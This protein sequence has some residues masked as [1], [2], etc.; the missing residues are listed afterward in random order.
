MSE[1][2][3]AVDILSL[4]NGGGAIAG[5]GETFA[6]N[7]FTGAG[8]AQV[9]IAV[10]AGRDGF[11]PDLELVYNSGSGNGPF[12]LGWSLGVPGV[13]RKTAKGVPVYDDEA[14]IFLL[15]QAEDLV[16]IERSGDTTSYRPRTE[17]TF[18]RIAHVRTTDQNYWEVRDTSGI[19]ARYG[20]PRPDD[21]D[22]SWSDP[23]VV[24]DPDPLHRHHIFSW[25]LSE[26]R[27]PFGN[28]VIYDYAPDSGAQIYLQRIRYADYHDGDET[29][30]LVEVRFHYERRPD[31][32]S[33]RRAGF[34]IRTRKRCTR[35]DILTHA[36]EPR[37]VRSYHLVYLDQRSD[38]P[39]LGARLP[40]NG[41]S[42]LSQVRIAGHDETTDLPPVEF[43]YSA[44]E[45][46]RSD[47]SAVIGPDLPA[48]SL[49]EPNMAVVDLDG[50]GLPDVLAFQ[51]TIRYWKNRGGGR[52]D[53]PREM[54]AAP[55]GVALGDEGVQLLDA[56]GN[57]RADLVVTR[58]PVTGY[59]PLGGDGQWDRRSFQA[60]RSAP[61]F[62]LAG[63]D[64]QL[65]DLTGDG[66]TDAVRAG[67]QLECFFHDAELGWRRS[68]AVS[69]RALEAFPN[70]EFSDPRVRWADMSGD[71]LTD[72]A[73]VY[74]GHIAYWPSLGHGSWGRRVSM[75]HCPRFPAG[76]DPHRV[77]VGDIDGDGLADVIYVDHCRVTVWINQGGAR[78][79]DPVILEGTPQ[80]T[81]RGTV[82]LLDL[83]GAG[84]AGIL[85]SE[86]AGGPAGHMWFLDVIGDRKPYLLD[87]I[88]NHRGATT[89]IHYAPSTRYSIADRDDP[90]LHWRTPLPFPLQVVARTEVI[91]QLSGGRL[92]T[93]FFY[94]H[95][96][97]D[98]VER[99]FRGF[100]RVDQ[101]DTETFSA[102]PTAHN[103]TNPTLTFS[104]PTES[105]TWFHLGPVELEADDWFELD[106]SA[107]HWPGDPGHL[108]RP[109][110]TAAFLRSLPRRA[111]RDA[112]RSLRGSVLRSELYSFDGSLRE[113]RPYSVT[114]TSYGIR[115]ESRPSSGEHADPTAR[116]RV[117]FPHPIASR[118]TQWERGADPMT[119]FTFTDRYNELGQAQRSISVAC[120]RGWRDRADQMAGFLASV[121][122]EDF[123]APLSDDV[124][125]RDRVARSTSYEL[126]GHGTVDSVRRAADTP[127]LLPVLGQEITYYD[128][129][130][131]T[132][133]PFGQ[134]GGY[135]L[136]ARSE[137]L[138]FT[139][140]ILDAA[141]GDAGAAPYLSGD[142]PLPSEYPP[143]FADS[144][145][146]RAG[147]H[148]HSADGV[149]IAGYYVAEGQTRYD[150]HD[151]EV[152]H[153][154]GLL[155]ATRDPLGNETTV[156]HDQP[157]QLLPVA[158]TDAVGL[159]TEASYDY[160]HLQV[161]ATIDAN[162]N[163]R[164]LAYDALGML[165]RSAVRGT[166]AEPGDSLEHPTTRF[167]RDVHA[168]ARD[169]SPAVTRIFQR[170]H[171]A[172]DTAVPEA[173]RDLVVESVQYTDGFG[174]LLQSRT[175]ASDVVFG[176]AVFGDGVLPAGQGD[177]VGTAADVIGVEAAGGEPPFV[178]V[179]GWTTYDN[180]G[181]VVEAYEPFYQRGWV[182]LARADAN[183]AAFGEKMTIYYDPLGRVVRRVHP[184]GSQ[185]RTIYGVPGRIDTPDPARPDRHEPTPWERYTYDA[186]D[187]A[188]VA[189]IV[190]PAPKSL[191]M[192]PTEHHFTPLSVELDAFGR[193]IRAV[194]RGGTDPGQWRTNTFEHDLANLIAATDALGRTAFRHVYDL[195][196]VQLR[197]ESID[198]GTRWVIVDAAGREI[199]RRDSKGA[200]VL[201]SYDSL[202]RLRRWWARDLTGEPVALRERLV[203]GDDEDAG[204]AEPAATNH[205]GALYRHYDEAGCITVERYDFTNNP[206]ESTRQVIAD[207]A[208]L[209]AFDGL[210]STD[211][212]PTYRVDWQ[213]PPGQSEQ[214]HRASLLDGTEYRIS[215]H[216]DALGRLLSVTYPQDVDGERKQARFRYNTGGE[217]E[218]A[219]LDGA[220]FVQHIAY[221]A[222]G[223]RTLVAYGNG[224]MTRYAY[225]SKT[226]ALV[227][228][229]SERYARPGAHRYRPQG[230]VVEDVAYRHDLVGNVQMIRNRTPQCG[231]P[232]TA[233]G[234]DA[235]DRQ[236]TYDPLYRLR[237]AT[238][239][240][241]AQPVA[242]PPWKQGLTSQDPNQTRA[243][244]EHYS[245]DSVGNL[246]RLAHNGGPGGSFTR[247]LTPAA[248]GNRLAVMS[249]GGTEYGY[250]YDVSGNMVREGASRHFEWDY[251]DQV[252][253][254]RVASGAVDSLHAHYLY[255]GSG[256]RT[257]K[258]VRKQNGNKIE[259]TINIAGLFEHHRIVQGNTVS[260]NNTLHVMDAESRLATV[261]V[262]A[263]FAGDDTPAVKYHLGDP[264]DTAGVVLGQSGAWINREEHT[265]YGET[266]FGG[267][268]YKRYRFAG[269]ERDEESGLDYHGARY[270][271]SWLGRW[272]SPDPA[273]PE[274][275]SN[276]YNF[277][278]GDPIGLDDP[279][280]LK[281]K[282]RKRKRRKGYDKARA[283]MKRRRAGHAG[284][285]DSGPS[286]HG[287]PGAKAGDDAWKTGKSEKGF[288]KT[289]ARQKGN[290]PRKWKNYPGTEAGHNVHHP[291]RKS[292]NKYPLNPEWSADNSQKGTIDTHR[293][294]QTR[295]PAPLPGPKDGRAY[296]K[297]A[298]D[299]PKPPSGAAELAKKSAKMSRSAAG[300]LGDVIA[301][302]A[303]RFVPGV[304]IAFGLHSAYENFEQGNVLKGIFDLGGVIPGPVGDVFDGIGTLY[305][306]GEVLLAEDPAPAEPE[307]AG[308]GVLE[309]VE[310]ILKDLE[311]KLEDALRP[312]LPPIPTPTPATPHGVPGR[313]P[314][315]LPPIPPPPELA[316]P[317]PQPPP[318]PPQQPIHIS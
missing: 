82:S 279:S 96:Y 215:T 37:L 223:T 317:P 124:Y 242:A 170:I 34:E 10:P 92:V 206:V 7:P 287:G 195:G 84:V 246:T 28:R 305:E 169:G 152:A 300:K 9:P 244:T 204:L 89:R 77:L 168:F 176:D 33:N 106:Y 61:S 47:L 18:A 164:A 125:I 57:G 222:S 225:D 59:Y 49:G 58:G 194:E 316:P 110:D 76:Y 277:A 257:K 162:G 142:G 228:R 99:E 133:L 78:F 247:A 214:A 29:Q 309:V 187:L 119:Q 310:G 153:P 208:I 157:Y 27:D 139:D 219:E 8:T 203:Y 236:F 290:S 136:P 251:A 148:R 267:Y 41:V 302:R 93:E 298:P 199:E 172:G 271:A 191:V 240:E 149:H 88:D 186:N 181:R 147:Y 229:R 39:G 230:P 198:S 275:E 118:S 137:K 303:K 97:Y 193:I 141:Y 281:P 116:P 306:V 60:Q 180:K 51:G 100:G 56:N 6:A 174:R 30:F 73:V 67:A 102:H 43:G 288:Y 315:D 140:D 179:S 25:Y 101:R 14:D 285:S 81:P 262:G 297:N 63:S 263:P 159:R 188:A 134:V 185:E 74:D 40:L 79:A 234:L 282:K 173:D 239:R 1:P 202:S 4:P 50:N 311:R 91:D 121:A 307:Q 245:Y 241:H 17:G 163:R 220:T 167:E 201:Q 44:F 308:P 66:I 211:P 158:V 318:P 151:P 80:V 13:V 150:V 217:L 48:Q 160:R 260:E 284:V 113:S 301:K 16:A 5:V 273:G 221:N 70:I 165:E 12:G 85:F 117:F 235:L 289:Q 249:S 45:P 90:V 120:P 209:S 52:F 15:S 115:E 227:R 184:D 112:V 145:P 272:T 283:D 146:A 114:E 122:V 31:S 293:R 24:A 75:A 226:F 32:F 295:N 259:V 154:R 265:P 250:E 19:T 71:G 292:G 237:S 72:I 313:I 104:P 189:A 261:R 69:R 216:H 224:V 62:D 177:A 255:D 108:Q 256:A 253:A 22:E 258:L 123:A 171:H 11:G 233:L 127:G 243:Y 87:T 54:G 254:F 212:V 135:G 278:F 161:V 3:S 252:R 266:S 68:R 156:E 23:A 46:K 312:L 280:G 138:V 218:S 143:A 294:P 231:I 210:S 2:K 107:E 197:T 205:L 132:G 64:V 182:Y 35:I 53:L 155:V 291:H 105:R 270:Y 274:D 26:T 268:A 178:V 55:Q 238:G 264:A 196:G 232:N 83:R 304:G 95:G 130:A 42:L 21:A 131:Y 98:G 190:D 314:L 213:P 20:T 175:R 103:D 65:V 111:R 248:A 86:D 276:L 286:K 38:L 192:P 207:A 144:L 36:D 296:L 109:A 129:D 183:E 128:G 126:P 200:L 299:I 166:A 269:K 94:H